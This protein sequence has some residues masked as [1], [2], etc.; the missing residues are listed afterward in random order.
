MGAEDAVSVVLASDASDEVS[1]GVLLSVVGDA[2][3]SVE[4]GGFVKCVSGC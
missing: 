3:E 2:A 1:V 4:S